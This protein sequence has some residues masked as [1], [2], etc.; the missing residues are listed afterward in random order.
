MKLISVL[1]NQPPAHFGNSVEHQLLRPPAHYFAK[2]FFNKCGFCSGISENSSEYGES[3]ILFL[4]SG[5]IFIIYLS[6]NL[7]AHLSSVF[8][9]SIRT[10]LAGTFVRW[11]RVTIWLRFVNHIDSWKKHQQMT[12]WPWS[13]V[14]NKQSLQKQIQSK[15]WLLI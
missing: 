5:F 8:Q 3:F 6:V 13:R 1:T 7:K 10:L 14:Q 11:S 12:I 2:T 9:I 15:D 4:Q